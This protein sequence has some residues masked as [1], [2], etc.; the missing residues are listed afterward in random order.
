[1]IRICLAALITLVTSCASQERVETKLA[2]F[3][4]QNIQVAISELGRP[5]GTYDM[6]DGTWEYVWKLQPKTSTT[7]N[8]SILGLPLSK[9][10]KAECTKVLTTDREKRVTSYNTSG[11]C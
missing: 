4:G 6:Q 9:S 3:V 7:A 2:G 1:M 5:S 8:T 11:N 10:F